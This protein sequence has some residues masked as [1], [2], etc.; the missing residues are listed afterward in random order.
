MKDGFL[1]VGALN[2]NARVGDPK[3]NAA[4]LITLAE[5]AADAGISV[6]ATPEL[7]LTT[8]TAGDLYRSSCLLSASEAALRDYLDGTAELDLLSFI[9]LPLSVGGKLYNAAAVAF[10]GRLLGVVPKTV[11]GG[12]FAPAPEENTVISYAG[13]TC[14]FGARQLFTCEGAPRLTVACEIGDD[15]TLPVPPS[16]GHA[17]A[18]ATLIVNLAADP[19]TVGRANFRRDLVAVHSARVKCAYVYAGAGKGE[20]GTDLVFSGHGLIAL[21]GKT[22]AESAPF[23]DAPILSAT[24]DLEFILSERL[25]APLS[26]LPGIWDKVSFDLH[27]IAV[28]TPVVPRLPFVPGDPAELR[29]RCDLILSIQSRALASRMERAYAKCAVVGVSGGLDSTLAMLVSVAAVDLLGLPRTAVRAVTMPCFGTTGRTRGN[30]EKLAESLGTS[31]SEV[32]IKASVAQHFAD[33]GHDPKNTN[34]VYENAQARERTQVLMDIA[35]GEGGLVVGT[36]DLSE[37][38]LG[39][40][41]Y[42]GDHMSMYGVNAGVPKTLMR[43]LVAAVANDYEAKGEG[44]VAAVLR[45]VLA[46]PVSPE[47]LPPENGEI[48]QKTE[49]IVGPYELHDFF[50]WYGVRCGYAPGKI[51]RLAAAAF[52][53]D[54]P[55]DEIY[56][57]EKTFFRRFFSQQFKRSCLADGP[58]IGSLSLSPRGGYAMPS[59][60]TSEAWIRDLDSRYAELG[61]R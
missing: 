50:L 27:E 26:P 19:E 11:A 35:N 61:G 42:N 24:V 45:D 2:P 39:W 46:T 56:R 13:E 7:A 49:G 36:G 21:T 22:V 3:A 57:W 18:G 48:A 12:V 54:Y 17:A 52:A 6:V 60:A 14:L 44:T 58:K 51:L 38:S 9:G 25:R 55:L 1:I 47:L 40:A 37:L 5:R 32:D 53:P 10:R 59:D 31:F 30:A 4:A 16:V 28:P 23:S 8:A 20:S 15:L 34:A 41:T 33:L 43:H 29:S